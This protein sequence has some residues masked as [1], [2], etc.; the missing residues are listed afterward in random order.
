MPGFVTH[1]EL[2]GISIANIDITQPDESPE[3]FGTGK[4]F[5]EIKFTKTDFADI[6]ITNAV[7]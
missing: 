2:I 4:V 1:T 7:K 3:F 6:E 5:R